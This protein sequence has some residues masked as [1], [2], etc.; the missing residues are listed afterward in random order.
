MRG[1][2]GFVLGLL[3]VAATAALCESIL[4]MVDRRTYPARGVFA[5]A[6]GFRLRLLPSGTGQPGPTVL[7]ETGIGGATSV[8]WA[9][10]Q[11]GVERFAPVVSYDRAGLGLSEPGPMP[12][13]GRRLVEELHTALAHAG[14]HPPYVFVGH[15]YGGLL[16][17]LYTDRYPDEVAG[18]VLCEASHPGQ[19]N[20][21][22]P[23]THGP[24]PRNVVQVLR[25]LSD[26]APWLA[27]LGVIRLFVTLVPTDAD[28]LPPLERGE[29]KA[30]LA[31]PAHWV[32]TVR[33]LAAWGPLTNPET[34]DTHGFGDRPMVVLTAGRSAARWGPWAEMQDEIARL[35]TDS[36][37]RTVAG[38]THG[39]LIAD[40]THAAVVVE[41]I[42]EVVDAARAGKPLRDVVAG[43][44]E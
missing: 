4:E 9:W 26:A 33:E 5:D 20:T 8:T 21:G 44:G 12:R 2:A 13:D 11:H 7:L 3:L 41:S 29:Q 24:T 23:G 18:L 35:S 22:R 36:I 6:G 1:F 30:F 37:H 19:F 25:S 28:R 27:R 40:S 43:R 39:S 16:A 17:R 14:I 31:T 15:S 10:V 38:A 42:R 32:G 34:R